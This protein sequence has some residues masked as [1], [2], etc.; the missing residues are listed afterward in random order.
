MKILDFRLRLSRFCRGILDCALVLLCSCALVHLSEAQEFLL[1]EP[2]ARASGFGEGCS[3]VEGDLS[4]S[5]SNPASIAT[6]SSY[7]IALAHLFWFGGV[8]YEYLSFGI[9]PFWE[10]IGLGMHYSFAGVEESWL[11]WEGKPKG[12]LKLSNQCL[13]TVIG[14]KFTEWLYLGS[15]VKIIKSTIGPSN[16]LVEGNTWAVDLGGLCEFELA[17]GQVNLSMVYQNLG[18]GI[19]LGGDLE[20]LPGVFR[21][22]VMYQ[23][24]MVRIVGEYNTSQLRGASFKSGVEYMVADL[25]VARAGYRINKRTG[26]PAVGLGVKYDFLEF[27]YA[28]VLYPHGINT[29]RL[30]LGICF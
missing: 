3:A 27:D 28:W 21:L 18:P 12:H 4:I 23:Y 6:L 29:H 11:D 13:T 15:G 7:Q 26:G 9:K 24:K 20:K 22:G 17:G 25:F 5:G 8:K 14:G 30:T 1:I 19:K 16:E 2:S 10:K